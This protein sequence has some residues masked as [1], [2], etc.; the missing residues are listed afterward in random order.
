ML[1][2]VIDDVRYEVKKSQTGPALT[3]K[4]KVPEQFSSDGYPIEFDMDIVVSFLFER[5]NWVA[6]KPYPVAV[7]PNYHWTAIPKPDFSAPVSRAL[8]NLSCN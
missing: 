8:G 2:L 1:T 5:N 6:A 7:H 4:V 3:L